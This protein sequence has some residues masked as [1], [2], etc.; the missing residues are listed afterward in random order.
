MGI[1]EW[2]MNKYYIYVKIFGT[3]GLPQFLP[4]YVPDKSLAREIPY[5]T[6]EKGA[7]SYLS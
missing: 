4:K 1:G 5:H 7:I 6:V 3:T 2:Y